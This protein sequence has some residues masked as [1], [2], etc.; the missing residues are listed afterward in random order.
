VTVADGSLHVTNGGVNTVLTILALSMR[1]SK[2]LAEELASRVALSL[3]P[4]HARGATKRQPDLNAA[5]RMGERRRGMTRDDRKAVTGSEAQIEELFPQTTLEQMVV[6]GTVRD[7]LYTLDTLLRVDAEYRPE[8]VVTDT[9]SYLD[10][11]FSWPG[12]G[13][14]PW[15]A[16]RS[17]MPC[18]GS[19]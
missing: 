16:T 12:S 4:T 15:M 19:A 5:D 10:M 3:Y 13:P 6:P 9:A 18:A 1:V 7:S 14:R 17:P 8:V 11:I 2:H